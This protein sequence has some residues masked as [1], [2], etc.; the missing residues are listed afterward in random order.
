MRFCMAVVGGRGVHS[1][2]VG[3]GVSVSRLRGGRVILIILISV[4]AGVSVS[5]LRGGRVILIILIIVFTSRAAGSSGGGS[6]GG[7]GGGGEGD[8]GEAVA[9]CRG[10]EAALRV[11]GAAAAP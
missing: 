6:E 1:Q 2:R 11:R 7:S 8:V 5:R 4:G 9:D 3:A 10:G